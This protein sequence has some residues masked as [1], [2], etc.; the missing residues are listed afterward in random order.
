[1]RLI[2]AG[3]KNL[4]ISILLL[5]LCFAFNEARRPVIYLMGDSTVATGSAA[6]A[7]KGWGGLLPVYFDTTRINISNRAVAGTSSRT[8]FT[9]VLHDKA[10]AANGLWKAVFQRLQPGD[11]VIMQFGHNDESPVWDSARSRGTIK[12]TGPDSSVAVN[13]FSKETET[14]HTY[15]WYIAAFINAIKSKNAIPIVCSPVPKN[16]WKDG[17]VIRNKDDYGKWA[18]EIATE[19]GVVYIDLNTLV[20][21]EYDKLGEAVV[22][23]EYFVSDGV[24]TTLKGAALSAGMVAAAIK[25]AQSIKLNTFL[26]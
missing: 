24:H 15:G 17:H 7:I 14:V 19:L 25:N 6:G 23:Q 11:Y 12:G 9:G 5:C 4:Y 20:A 2:P 21:D 26:K 13:P 16:R 1:M 8:Y 22:K 3:R 18:A 10:W